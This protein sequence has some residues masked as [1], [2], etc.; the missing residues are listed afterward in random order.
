M[1]RGFCLDSQNTF[2]LEGLLQKQILTFRNKL[3]L[4]ID[5][6]FPQKKICRCGKHRMIRWIKPKWVSFEKHCSIMQTK[7]YKIYW[8]YILI[9][10]KESLHD[11]FSFCLQ[12]LPFCLQLTFSVYNF[13]IFFFKKSVLW[14]FY[15]FPR[16]KWLKIYSSC[17]N[18]GLN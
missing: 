4:L 9:S 5:H 14:L 7:S 11:H 1:F 18:V 6:M 12:F 15:N 10:F 16:F 13:S 17:V 3:G 2:S 8:K